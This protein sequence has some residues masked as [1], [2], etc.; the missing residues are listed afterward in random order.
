MIEKKVRYEPTGAALGGEKRTHG[1]GC[2]QVR[3]RIRS[4]YQK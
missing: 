2:V 1:A 3:Y 4:L